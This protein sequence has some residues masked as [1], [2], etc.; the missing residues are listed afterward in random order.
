VCL[1]ALSPWIIPRAILDVSWPSCLND[2]KTPGAGSH[3]RHRPPACSQC[4]GLPKIRL[5]SIHHM[6]SPPKDGAGWATRANST[7]PTP[8]SGGGGLELDDRTA[9][10]KRYLRPALRLKQEELPPPDRGRR[11]PADLSTDLP[12]NRVAP[13]AAHRTSGLAG[14]S[15][16]LSPDARRSTAPARRRAYSVCSNEG[17]GTGSRMVTNSS[18]AVG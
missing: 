16:G 11:G 1:E 18:A 8:L 12:R 17:S 6:V 15:W 9:Q 13:D 14:S 3:T 7:E 4:Q 2:P 5:N 10:R